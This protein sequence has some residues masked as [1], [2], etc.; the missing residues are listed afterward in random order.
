MTKF[1]QNL[2]GAVTELFN[3]TEESIVNLICIV[4]PWLT[5][6][7]PASMTYIHTESILK[8]PKWEA[9][10]TA[11][12]VE[13]LGFAAIRT[14]ISFME[15]NKRYTSDVRRAPLWLSI[16]V[17]IFYLVV[18][19]TVNV[20]LQWTNDIP[21]ANIV[22]TGL[23]SLLSVP[24]AVLVA[25]RAQ[26]AELLRE[27]SEQKERRRTPNEQRTNTERTGSERTNRRTANPAVRSSRSFGGLLDV[28]NRIQ[29]Y[30]ERTENEQQRTPGPTEIS[31]A[32]GVS[33]GYASDTLKVIRPRTDQNQ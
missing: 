25:V 15:H 2:F 10:V 8:F 11:A 22:A 31:Q 24:G 23:L 27:I 13:T 19:L 21:T 28:R 32:L 33:K 12:I 20:Y 17:Y 14:I 30:V 7:V 29:E 5:T 26:H 9:F 6:I 3:G 18:I 16:S 4:S 1:L